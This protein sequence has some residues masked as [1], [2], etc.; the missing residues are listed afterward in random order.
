MTPS[1]ENYDLFLILPSTFPHWDEQ[2]ATGLAN[3]CIF[4]GAALATNVQRTLSCC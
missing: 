2:N 1:P 3:L 4:S